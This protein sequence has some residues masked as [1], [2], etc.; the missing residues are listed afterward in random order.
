MSTK[1]VVIVTG[2]A[3]GIGRGI[4]LRLA[5][6]GFDVVVNDIPANQQNLEAVAKLIAEK[7]RKSLAI[8]G[9][10]SKEDD[11]RELV[12][13]TVDEFGGLDVVGLQGGLDVSNIRF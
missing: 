9:D 5:A 4:A 8:T 1:G 10:V 11:V 13:K 3:Q 12:Q 2:A 7:G 6:D